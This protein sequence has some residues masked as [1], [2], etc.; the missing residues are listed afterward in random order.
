MLL[1][2]EANPVFASPKAWQVRETLAK[3]PYIASFGSF[4]DDTS[5]HADL[6]LPD[7]SFLESWVDSTPESGSIE[8]VTTVAGPVM[9]PLHNTRATADVLIEVAGKLKSPV[10]LPWKTAEELANSKRR[11]VPV[12]AVPSP[13]SGSRASRQSA[14]YAEPQFDGDAAHVSVP[15]PAVRVAG[16][17]RRLGRA[18]AVAAGD[19]RPAHLGDVEQLGGD[20]SADR[21]APGRRTG[22]S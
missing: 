18:P 14:R 9:K 20:Q 6:I 10:A 4:I 2:D 11:R 12:A 7:H 13:Q 21:R 3:I 17:Q 5:S 1:L 8:P 16:L 22:R 15:L 19:A